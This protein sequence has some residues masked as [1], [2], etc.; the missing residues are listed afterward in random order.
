MDRAWW[1]VHIA[2]VNKVF[3]GVRYSN[4]PLSQK[5]NV[6]KLNQ[7]KF[8]TYGNSG[9]SCISLAAEGGAKRIVLLG[10]DVQKSEGKTHWHGDHPPTLGNAGQISRWHDKFAEQSKALKHLEIINCSRE[11]ALTC[12][13]RANLEDV[14]T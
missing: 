14:L 4:N 6:K 5:L 13:P 9:A 10:F 11:T 3:L 7:Q 12:Y 1:D 8:K 2:E